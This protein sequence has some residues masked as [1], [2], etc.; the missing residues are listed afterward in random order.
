[1]AEYDASALERAVE[2]AREAGQARQL[3]GPLAERVRYDRRS[4]TL[5]IY[6]NTGYGVM[7]PVRSLQ[8]L[9]DATP[10]QLREVTF[11]PSRTGIRFPALDAD[12]SLDGLLKGIFGTERWM[13]DLRTVAAKGGSARSAAKVNAARANGKK[14]G[15]PRKQQP[16]LIVAP[17]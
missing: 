16:H 1:M 17:E 8:G 5:V 13:Q 7:I 10:E 11:G 9:A 14:G 4:R 6:L 12:F 2:S 15:R 3:A